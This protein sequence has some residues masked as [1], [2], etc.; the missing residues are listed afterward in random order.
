LVKLK[1]WAEVGETESGEKVEKAI[2][3]IFPGENVESAEGRKFSILEIPDLEK[4]REIFRVKKIGKTV[5]ALLEKS[6]RPNFLKLMFNKQAA[7]MGRA[8]LVDSQNLSPLGAVVLEI[9][10]YDDSFLHWLTGFLRSPE[11]SRL[12]RRDS[13]E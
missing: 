6:E 1:A 11:S 10:D 12:R 7:F 5:M 3:G 8:V 4:L 2:L 13:S 9:K